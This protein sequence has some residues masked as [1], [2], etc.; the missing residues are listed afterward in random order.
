MS[1]DLALYIDHLVNQ[2]KK[3]FTYTELNHHINQFKYLGNGA[4]DKPFDVTAGKLSGHA[5]QNWCLLRML[6]V[7]V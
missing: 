7:L 1:F 6:P 4:R 5:V 3:K 2:D